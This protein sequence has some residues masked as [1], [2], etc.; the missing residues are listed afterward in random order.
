MAFVN[1]TVDVTFIIDYEAEVHQV[2]QQR[3]SLFM[4]AVELRRGVRGKQKDFPVYGSVVANQ[5]ARHSS[6]VPLNP[7][8]SVETATL[9]DRYA[10]IYSDTLDELKTNIDERKAAARAGAWA[11]G[12]AA[13]LDVTTA[14][15]LTGNTI[16]VGTSGLTLAKIR[17][18]IED[19]DN[20]SVPADDRWGFVGSHQ[21][22][23]L[24]NVDEFATAEFVGAKDLPF[25]TGARTKFWNGINWVWHPNLPLENSDAERACYL[26]HR[27]AIGLAVGQDIT[28][29]V[30]Y[31]A[32]K[33]AFL[34]NHK[35]SM[36]S[37]I[38]EDNGIV[39]IMCDDDKA[40]S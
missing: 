8:H 23:E 31:I 35:M 26:F 37:V 36:G 22:Q 1:P 12:R 21:W 14:L 28:L 38:I 10:G 34:I 39:E 24:M 4:N 5:K 18:G 25:A 20:N 2:F 40:I 16:A 32:E 13:D 3:G 33:D 30:S 15:Q 17:D 9:V 7:D 11:L 29:I 27:S 19:L 6:I